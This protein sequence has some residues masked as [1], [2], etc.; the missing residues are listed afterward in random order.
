MSDARITPEVAQELYEALD[1]LYRACFGPPVGAG[2]GGT[3]VVGTPTSVTLNKANAA[4]ARARGE[5]Q[6]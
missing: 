3:Y 4:L 6:G 1:E 5:S 2:D